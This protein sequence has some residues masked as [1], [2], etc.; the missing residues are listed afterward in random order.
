[1]GQTNLP[2]SAALGLSYFFRIKGDFG[3]ELLSQYQWLN[4]RVEVDNIGGDNWR[5]GLWNNS[6]GLSF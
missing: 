4:I 6:V 3:V 5:T 2:N 1:L